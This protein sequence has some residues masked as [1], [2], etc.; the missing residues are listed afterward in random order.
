[1]K[2]PGRVCLCDYIHGN[3]RSLIDIRNCI[4]PTISQVIR[5]VSDNQKSTIKCSAI[6]KNVL[7]CLSRNLICC[8]LSRFVKISAYNEHLLAFFRFI[9]DVHCNFALF[10]ST[11]HF[12]VSYINETAFANRHIFV[13]KFSKT[14]RYRSAGYHISR[15][16][17]INRA[18]QPP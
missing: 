16:V 18:R 11:S 12:I 4:Y 14:R 13:E 15:T 8:V 2:F 17:S 10:Q 6:I 7:F 9:P 5:D 3:W 1:M